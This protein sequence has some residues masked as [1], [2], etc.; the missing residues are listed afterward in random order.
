[1]AEIWSSFA[2]LKQSDKCSH[3]QFNARSESIKEKASFRRLIPKNRCLVSVE[4]YALCIHTHISFFSVSSFGSLNDIVF[5]FQAYLDLS[6][7]IM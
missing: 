6:C 1:M 3:W 7:D 2:C 5:L 4:G